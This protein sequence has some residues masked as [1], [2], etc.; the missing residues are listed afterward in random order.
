MKFKIK[1]ALSLF[2]ISLFTLLVALTSTYFI[3]KSN[4]KSLDL[5]E[6][7]NRTKYIS[8]TINRYI[9]DL[10]R[11]SET[12]SDSEVILSSLEDSNTGLEV[13]SPEN[14]N[15][16]I[17]ELNN[18][19]T[20]TD[21][22]E[23]PLVYSTL[24]NDAALYLKNQQCKS[25]ELFGEL[26]LTNKYG[27]AISSTGK[28]TTLSHS[29]KYW[30]VESYN[31]GEGAI[32]IDDRG[33]DESVSGYVL[34]IVIP[35]YNHESE[36]IGLL[37]CNYNISAIFEESI[38]FIQ[39][40]HKDGN[41]Y[42]VRT[43]GLVV[44]GADIE[45]L[46]ES[47]SNELLPLLSENMESSDEYTIEN[48]QHYVSFSPIEITLSEDDYI[49]GGRYSSEDHSLGNQGESWSVLYVSEEI[50][51]LSF[52]NSL[53]KDILIVGLVVIFVLS[54]FS[55]FLG[56]SLSKPILKLNRYVQ[57]IG[58]GDLIKK[59]IEMPNDEIGS[60]TV[61]FNHMLDH[62]KETL[63]SK[64]ELI[65]SESRLKKSQSIAQVGSWEL[66]IQ[67]NKIWASD[68]TFKIYGV[69]QESNY[70]EY[71]KI[72]N[73][74][75]RVYRKKLDK[76]MDDLIKRNK[77][78]DITYSIETNEG[79]KWIHSVAEIKEDILDKSY[80]VIGVIKDI[81]QTKNYERE[82]LDNSYHDFLTGLYNRRFFVKKY[83]EIVKTNVYPLGIMMIDLNGLKIINDS[84]GHISGDYAIKKVGAVLLESLIDGDFVARIGGDEFAVLFTN[85]SEE[86]ILKYRK[87]VKNSIS[88]EM[89][90]N[91]EISIS[92]GYEIRKNMDGS[93]V[94]DFLTLAENHMYRHK[95]LE[96]S[97]VRNKAIKAIFRT[98]TDKYSDERNHSEKVSVLCK[99][100]GQAMGLPQD[101]VKELEMAGLYHDIGKISIPDSVLNKPSRL[102]D[103][104]FAIIKTHPEVSYQILKAADEYSD[105]AIHALYHHERIDGLGYPKGKVGE[106][107]PLFSRIIAVCDSYEVMTSNRVY[108]K[109]MSNQAAINELIRCS[110]A[111][112]DEEIAKVFVTKVLQK[113][114]KI[115]DE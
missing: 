28:L 65:I 52:F 33:Y 29:H 82:L 81:T 88:K 102:T 83:N 54:I 27:V 87:K 23:V 90:G 25:P 46:T 112:F 41:I 86:K 3:T 32:Y 97:S 106:D 85:T 16:L 108:K 93:T 51:F 38:S 31:E 114:W 4:T 35:I 103:E 63:V 30:W 104:E 99:K 77:P 39:S 36:I 50:T 68:E 44:A 76:Q 34:G 73:I 74:P 64:N 1:M 43:L 45:P 66:D 67:T 72:K 9:D 56:N 37:K 49:F 58:K 71:D 7:L 53:Y 18:E 105:I 5:E 60:L 20:E 48:N 89:I 61:S 98:L 59:D 80:K 70:I 14:R 47:V 78:Y 96:S 19:W 62:L 24:N 69:K 15:D 55:Y 42:I 91:V 17:E 92:V 12:I 94:D 21:D 84:L 6:N 110:N 109:A 100:L 115:L 13:L 75:L 57:E 40:D 111:Q 2:L 10:V 26:F 11:F 79:I 95:V 101:E 22:L 8:N 113:E 107:I